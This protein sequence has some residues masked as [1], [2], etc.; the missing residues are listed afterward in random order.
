MLSQVNVEG[1]QCSLCL[2]HLSAGEL[3]NPFPLALFI[4]RTRVSAFSGLEESCHLVF[5]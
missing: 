5:E 3:E 2:G 1:L 4:Q